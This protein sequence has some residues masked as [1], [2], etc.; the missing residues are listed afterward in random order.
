MAR[1]LLVA[2]CVWPLLL[3]SS[4][5]ARHGESHPPVWTQ[6]LYFAAGR[7]CHQRP[8]R[9]FATAGVQWPVC[10]RCSGL[11]LSA[12]FG[13]A[14]AWARRR[15]LGVRRRHFLIAALPTLVTLAMEW[16][17]G[18]AVSNVTRAIAAL[19]LGFAIAWLLVRVTVTSAETDQ[20]H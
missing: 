6:A 4:V 11:Y 10:G 18:I 9:S 17:G 15:D 2:A 3:A 19:P 12:P 20:V 5:W 1:A 14:W 8:E 13:A 7:I 16:S